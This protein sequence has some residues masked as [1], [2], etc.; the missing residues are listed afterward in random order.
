MAT[1]DQPRILKPKRTPYPPTEKQ[2]E[3]AIKDNYRLAWEETRAHIAEIYERYATG[4]TLTRTDMVK[5]NRLTKTEQQLAG[6][7]SNMYRR[8]KRFLYQQMEAAFLAGYFEQVF[9]LEMQSD[10]LLGFGGV[11]ER[12]FTQLLDSSLT[13]LTLNERLKKNE[14]EIVAQTRQALAQALAQGESY[15]QTAKRFL[16]VYEGDT[17]KAI[18]IAWTETHRAE[19]EAAFQAREKAREK[20]DFEE[21]WLATLDGRTRDSHKKMDGKKK[22]ENGFFKVGRYDA[23]YPGDP[24]LPAKEVVHC[25]CTVVTRFKDRP[26]GERRGR[27]SLDESTL[28]N[29]EKFPANMT[30]GEWY[31]SRIAGGS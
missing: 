12:A 29:N 4:E 27:K 24:R 14:R 10:I 26:L 18:R 23:R 9:E 31:Q 3:K 2:L 5:Y 28:Q 25:R 13:G 17:A 6:I 1:T 20:L 7:L 16:D 30:Y 8:N 19:E 21:I 22:N 11:N 15:Q